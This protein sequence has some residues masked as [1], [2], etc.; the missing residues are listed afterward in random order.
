[1]KNRVLASAV[2][3]LLAA[4]GGGGDSGTTTAPTPP[5][6]PA[7]P[8]PPPQTEQLAGYIGNWA[9]DCS[10]HAIQT[11]AVSRTAGTINSIT[12]AFKSDYYVNAD[13]TGNIVGTWAQSADVT[14]VHVDT[15]DSAIVFAVN[16]NPVAARVDRV[17]IS[18]A[19]HTNSVTG[20]GVTRMVLNG[21]AQ[22]CISYGNNTASCIRDE[23]TYPAMSGASAG[24]YL[25]GN[26][27]YE[28]APGGMRF[29]AGPR[30]TKK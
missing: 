6:S 30:Y 25:Q 19:Q 10:D 5:T 16:G 11:V 27:M 2:M 28:L 12:L 17:S 14:A 20:S 24:F 1:M 3:A 18:Q 23:G 15:V 29:T 21:V 26:T 7:P 22:W 9:A 4:C 8:P 13:C